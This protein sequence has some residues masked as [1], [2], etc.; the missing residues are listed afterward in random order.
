MCA[1]TVFCTNVQHFPLMVSVDM[2]SL[3]RTELIF[4]WSCC[5]DKWFPTRYCSNIFCQ[6]FVKY[7]DLS[8]RFNKTLAPWLTMLTRLV[9]LLS[10]ETPDFIRPQ[11]WPPNSLDFNPVDYAIWGI[12]RERLYRCQIRG[13][14]H[15]K[16]RLIHEWHCFDQHIRQIS[17][18][19]VA[20]ED[21][22]GVGS[23]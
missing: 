21:H 6:P 18:L 22:F 3:G 11:Y 1:L 5:E 17:R 16:E 2:S 10:A 7:L 8:S 14:E 19:V 9:A 15:L 13:V 23:M 4:Y 12:L 20:A